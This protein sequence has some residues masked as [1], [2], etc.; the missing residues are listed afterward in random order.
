LDQTFVAPRT[1]LEQTIAELWQQALK[2]ERVGL[3][4][5]FFD[6][7]AHS[8]IVVRVHSDLKERLHREISLIEVFKNPTVSALAEYLSGGQTPDQTAL[9]DGAT[10][11]DVRRERR[12]ARRAAKQS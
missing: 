8:L 9:Q 6:L 12:K 3:H 11:G 1:E 4:D 2:V 5:N 7:G 10:R